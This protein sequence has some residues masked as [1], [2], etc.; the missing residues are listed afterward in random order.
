MAPAQGRRAQIE[1]CKQFVVGIIFIGRLGVI[2]RVLGGGAG[3]AAR[4]VAVCPLR[5]GRRADRGRE[6]GSG[7]HEHPLNNA[8][9]SPLNNSS[10]DQTTTEKWNYVGKRH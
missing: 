8:T 4:A 2:D 3:I 1:K 10:N 9:E 7:K 6:A 5:R